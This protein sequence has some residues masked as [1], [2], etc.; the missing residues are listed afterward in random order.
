MNIHFTRPKPTILRGCKAERA[1]VFQLALRLDD[2]VPSLLDGF[3][4]S[5]LRP[6]VRLLP[7]DAG[8]P[9]PFRSD[10]S[11]TF[12]VALYGTIAHALRALLAELDLPSWPDAADLLD[13]YYPSGLDPARSALT[14]M[15]SNAGQ[16]CFDSLTAHALLAAR[17][18]GI[19]LAEPGRA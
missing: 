9:L 16:R 15:V 2:S 1:M 7:L 13:I 17:R 18:R 4:T 5:A 8:R 10:F 12:N 14:V 19:L 6:S 3:D 11:D